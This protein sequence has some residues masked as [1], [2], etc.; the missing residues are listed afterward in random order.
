MQKFEE[1]LSKYPTA[2]TQTPYFILKFLLKRLTSEGQ[3]EAYNLWS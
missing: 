3:V 2:M 1:I